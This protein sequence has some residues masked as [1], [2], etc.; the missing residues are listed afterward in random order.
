VTTKQVASPIEE[1]QIDRHQ[2]RPAAGAQE[3]AGLHLRL[4]L[5][6]DASSGTELVCPQ[7]QDR[8][9][10]NRRNHDLIGWDGD[11]VGEENEA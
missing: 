10:Q 11:D 8:E 5:E 4:E 2:Q 6:H 3:L 7:H 9:H 1:H